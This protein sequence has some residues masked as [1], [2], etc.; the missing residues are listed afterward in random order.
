MPCVSPVDNAKSIPYYGN[1]KKYVIT[2]SI[3]TVFS[4]AGGQSK[5][6][7]IFNDLDA[8]MLR[9]QASD[10]SASNFSINEAQ[11]SRRIVKIRCR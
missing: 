6:L 2:P 5:L 8:I 3:C 9:L 7:R 4:A 1:A 11:L 10:L